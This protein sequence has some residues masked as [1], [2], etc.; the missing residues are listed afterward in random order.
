MLDSKDVNLPLLLFLAAT[1]ASAPGPQI[2]AVLGEY[3]ATSSRWVHYQSGAQNEPLTRLTWSHA[4][5]WL[6]Q[7]SLNSDE[8]QLLVVIVP[9]GRSNGSAAELWQYDLATQERKR[10]ARG[11]SPRQAALFTPWGPLYVTQTGQKKHLWLGTRILTQRTADLYWPLRVE[12]K[13]AYILAL[14]EKR[15]RLLRMD[16][17]SGTLTTVL[18]FG[19]DPVRDFSFASNQVIYQRQL[20]SQEFAIERYNLDT[21]KTQT[22]VQSR[23]PWLAPLRVSS[24]VLYS[25]SPSAVTGRLGLWHKHKTQEGPSVGPGAP[26]PMTAYKNH[27]VVRRQSSDGQSYFLWDAAGD[28]LEQINTQGLL[29]E[30][31]ILLEGKNP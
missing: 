28:V 20:S 6:P 7:V 31:V 3:S 11:L 9:P 1:P 2:M 29:M 5:G 27:A 18:D 15:M 22:L 13:H 30:S 19:S 12:S 16:L 26:I 8:N 14:F 17:P 10:W 24:R 25:L 4:S 21:H 23:L